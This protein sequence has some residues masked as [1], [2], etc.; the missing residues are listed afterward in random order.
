MILAADIGNTNITLGI[1]END[2]PVCIS[3]L[4]T[5]RH[6]TSEQYAIELNA[7]LNLEK[8]DKK[9][10][11]AIISSVVPE[12][13]RIFKNA[14]EKVTD[15]DALVVAAGVKNG[16]K[17]ITDNP[18]E[19]GADLVCG[20][21]GAIS[22][23]PLPCLVMDLGTATKISVIDEGGLF[24]GCTIA[25]GIG[26]SLDALSMRTSQLPAIELSAPEHAI[27]TNTI[28]CI[29]SGTVLGNAAML[30]GMA[31]RL[32][33]ELGKP[34]K[35]LVATGGLAKEIVACCK[36]DI[37]YNKDLVLEGLLTIYKKNR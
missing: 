22:Q 4:A 5:Q 8:L 14:I 21:V 18:K 34:I 1:Y 37:I 29:R 32:E 17:I 26:I 13:T 28:E 19:L 16:L 9:I 20:A 6:R 10:T 30:D 12:L 25:P 2:K 3:R 31:D 27:G 24:A 7:I 15:C 35:T 23:Y 11:G 36:K 33:A